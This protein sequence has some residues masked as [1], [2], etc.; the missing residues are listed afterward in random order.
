MCDPT[1]LILDEP[2]AGVNPRLADRICQH[3][4]DLRD[5]GVTLLIVEHNLTLVER[6][7]DSVTVMVRGRPIATGRMDELRQ[8][9]AVVDAYLGRA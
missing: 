1:L 9:Q 3:L 6:M 2:M 5:T 4:L 7:C 8:D